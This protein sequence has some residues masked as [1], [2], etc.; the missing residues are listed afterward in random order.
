GFTHSLLAVA[1]GIFL[2]R[3]QVPADWGIPLDVLHAMI[4]GYLSHIMADMLT[5]A[6]VPLLWPCRWRF[7]LPILNSQR[8]NQLERTLCLVLVGLAVWW[9][10]GPGFIDTLHLQNI[11]QFLKNITSI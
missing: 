6:G 11:G 4:V 9:Q 1:S 3:S 7:R 8:G 2:F 10:Q 5:P